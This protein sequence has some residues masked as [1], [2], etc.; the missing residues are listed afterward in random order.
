[1]GATQVPWPC[2]P[3]S[4]AFGFC[5]SLLFPSSLFFSPT[6]SLSLPRSSFYHILSPR[7]P[8]SLSLLHLLSLPSTSSVSSSVFWRKPKQ[9][10]ETHA[11]HP[12]FVSPWAISIVV[13]PLP[14]WYRVTSLNHLIINKTNIYLSKYTITNW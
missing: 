2:K 4:L 12:G 7:I 3:P 8:L 9:Y 10:S 5:H 14:I 6:S 13:I 1:M 11:G